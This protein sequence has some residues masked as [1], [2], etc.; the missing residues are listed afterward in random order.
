MV[1]IEIIMSDISQHYFDDKVITLEK[2]IS[3]TVEYRLATFKMFFD[4]FGLDLKVKY[5]FGLALIEFLQW[6]IESGRITND[7]STGSA[8][9]KGINGLMTIDLAIAMQYRL[10]DISVDRACELYGGDPPGEGFDHDHTGKEDEKPTALKIK[11][12]FLGWISFIK[13]DYISA[14]HKLWEAHQQ[15]ILRGVKLCNHLTE[16]LDANEAEFTEILLELLDFNAD[17]L[18][19]TNSIY[20]GNQA[21]SYYPNSYPIDEG[22]LDNLRKTLSKVDQKRLNQ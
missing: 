5:G 22:T 20:L 11:Y 21:K 1:K 10:G 18:T 6:E 12:P 4:K 14:Q 3:L 15:S 16:G 17:K 13:S 8:W 9:F 7:P 2:A 19:P